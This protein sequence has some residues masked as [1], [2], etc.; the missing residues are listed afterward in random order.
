MLDLQHQY[1]NCTTT[2]HI[3]VGPSVVLVLYKNQIPFFIGE[4]NFIKVKIYI[5]IYIYI[6]K[7]LNIIILFN[8][9]LA[10]VT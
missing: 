4:I 8:I 5:Y 9:Y 6:Y 10:K 2:P 1:N 7:M 3:R